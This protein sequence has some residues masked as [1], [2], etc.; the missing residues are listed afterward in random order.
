MTRF[1]LICRTVGV[2]NRVDFDRFLSKYYL[3]I[4]ISLNIGLHML[5]KLKTMYRL[6]N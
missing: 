1:E 4:T 6:S 2:R 3:F 5:L